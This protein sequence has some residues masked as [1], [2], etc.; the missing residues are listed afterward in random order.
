MLSGIKPSSIHPVYWQ[1]FT[2]PP[3]ALQDAAAVWIS[4]SLDY[5]VSCR[6]E[7]GTLAKVRQE[8]RGSEH[9]EKTVEQPQRLWVWVIEKLSSTVM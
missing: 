1:T 9:L 3:G 8:I 2:N 7:G 5:K 6:L 4:S